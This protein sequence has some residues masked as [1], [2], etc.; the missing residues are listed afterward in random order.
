MGTIL[1]ELRYGLRTLTK[2]PAFSIVAVLTLALGIGASTAIFSVVDAV[3]LRALPYPHPENLVRVWEQAPDGHRMN[4]AD[5]NFDDLRAQNSTLSD[6][7]E[8]EYGLLS[9][10]GGSEPVRVQA[11]EVSSNFFR[12]L[13]VEPFLGRTFVAEEQQL[14]GRPAVIV[15]YG[16]WQRYLAGATDLSKLRLTLEEGVYPVI[17]VMPETF[18]F[19]AGVAAWTVKDRHPELPSRTAHNWRAIGRIRRHDCRSGSCKPQLDRSPHP[20]SVWK[21]S[22]SERRGS[23]AA[24]R[25]DGWRCADGAVH[26][27][28][29]GRS[30]AA[31]GLRECRGV[32]ARAQLG[33]PKGTGRACRA[34][35][36]S[37]AP[38]SP[39]SDGVFFVLGRGR[40]AGDSGR[41][42]VGR[43]P[44]RHSSGEPSASGRYHDQYSGS[45]VCIHC[46]GCGRGCVGAVRRVAG[47]GGRCPGCIDRGLA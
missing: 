2:S 35:R 21:G 6:L 3:L 20:G 12:T 45:V 18:D 29:R 32:A 31:G 43:R 7:S 23:G 37:C 22:R 10:A 9:V 38:R 17:G 13:G 46:H 41:N 44:S 11:A 30:L 16:F 24:F 26:A 28:G 14:H 27:S 34:R 33:S 47:G 15:S 19:P 8:Y 40:R 39:I 36:R 4:F 25:C 1:R 5:P 42:V